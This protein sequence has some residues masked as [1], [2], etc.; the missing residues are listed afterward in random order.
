MAPKERTFAELGFAADRDGSY[1]AEFSIREGQQIR[2]IRGPGRSNKQRALGDLNIIRAAAPEG[3]SRADGFQAMEAAA[4]RLKDVAAA[5][6]GG[7]EKV[8][9]E[10]RARVQY[11]TTS[12]ERRVIQGP[13]R[14]DERRA[15]A[16]LEAMRAAAQNQPS[17]AEHLKAMADKAHALQEHAVFE[18][19]V[20]SA[21]ADRLRDGAR[22]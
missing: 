5:E 2:H 17:R 22:A 16:D 21:H 8:G 12:G 7:L 14:H 4:K 10:H 18:T 6:A 13:R 1:R 20:A 3:A 11:L 9:D 19:Q 15:Q